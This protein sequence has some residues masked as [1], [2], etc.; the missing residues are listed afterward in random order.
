M[1]YSHR[2]RVAQLYWH[3]SELGSSGQR[4]IPRL[5]A[6]PTSITSVSGGRSFLFLEDLYSSP[7]ATTRGKQNEQS[8]NPS[9]PSA[10]SHRS[11]RIYSKAW[12]YHLIKQG[13]F[14]QPVKIG[15]R[16][17]AFGESEV[18]EWIQSVIETTRKMLPEAGEENEY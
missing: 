6:A 3:C 12:I 18:E 10:S 14:P 17:I 5:W 15:L 16:A 1:S 7:I 9:H 8:T 11:N 13:R 4:E 2:S